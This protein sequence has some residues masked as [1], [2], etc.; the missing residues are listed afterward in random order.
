M[1]KGADVKIWLGT[2]LAAG[3]VAGVV[4]YGVYSDRQQKA[5]W[6]RTL[7]EIDTCAPLIPYK[8]DGKTGCWDTKAGLVYFKDGTKA[9]KAK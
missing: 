9:Q 2:A 6:S 5:N 8:E 7:S 4:A 3:V 1:Q